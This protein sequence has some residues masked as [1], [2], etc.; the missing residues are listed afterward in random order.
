MLLEELADVGLA[1]RDGNTVDAS[2]QAGA[3]IICLKSILSTKLASTFSDC[4]SVSTSLLSENP[5]RRRTFEL[6]VVN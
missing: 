6:E 3:K 5:S 1:K 4:N 2:F